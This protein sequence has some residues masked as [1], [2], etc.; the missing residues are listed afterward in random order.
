M[1]DESNNLGEGQYTTSEQRTQA[2]T[3]GIWLFIASEVMMFGSLILCYMVYR[4]RSPENFIAGGS[5]MATF[6]GTLNT[7]VLLT[8][9]FMVAQA[10]SFRKKNEM[11]KF[12]W[13]L[14]ISCA[15]GVLFC[16]IKSYE[17]WQHA[18]EGLLPGYN[19]DLKFN[20]IKLF[21]ILYF[22]L[23]GLH[24]L[25]VVIASILL[26]MLAVVGHRQPHSRWVSEIFSENVALYWH[27]VDV[28]WVVL[29]PLFYL[30]Q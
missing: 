28:I 25:H 22:I 17:Y 21:F 27:F 6:L 2:A 24:T 3:L 23:T 14:F 26:F 19:Y 16:G 12:S 29:Y 11:C 5:H 10:V 20:Q 18:S 30:I 8:S 9:S 4:Y 7:F 1:I 15:L 13:F